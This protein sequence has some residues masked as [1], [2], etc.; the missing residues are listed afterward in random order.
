[1]RSLK[2]LLLGGALLSAGCDTFGTTRSEE[3]RLR[4]EGTS[5]VDIQGVTATLFSVRLDD[6][7]GERTYILEESDTVMVLPPFDEVYDISEH[8]IFLVRLSNGEQEAADVELEIFIDG[9][10]KI[11]QPL[12]IGADEEGKPGSFEWSWLN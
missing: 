6:D 8:G 9:S 10:R 4:L 11:R 7:T 3:A 1:M 12:V 5:P 2:L